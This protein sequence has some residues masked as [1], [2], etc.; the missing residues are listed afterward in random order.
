MLIELEKGQTYV[1]GLSYE[2]KMPWITD[3]KRYMLS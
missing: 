2:L 1:L 3:G